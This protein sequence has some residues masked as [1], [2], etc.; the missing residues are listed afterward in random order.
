MSKLFSQLVT[1]LVLVAQNGHNPLSAVVLHGLSVPVASRIAKVFQ[2]R[3][4]AVALATAHVMLAIDGKSTCE[5]KT[6]LPLFMTYA[7]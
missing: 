5:S 3:C 2:G 7:A 6:G 1:D 4:S